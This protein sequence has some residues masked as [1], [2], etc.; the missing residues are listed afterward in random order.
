MIKIIAQVIVL[1]VCF[2][3]GIAARLFTRKD[4]AQEQMFE[5]MIVEIAKYETS[6]D[7]EPIVEKIDEVIEKDNK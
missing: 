6:I 4:K 1:G 3:I 2:V 5:D 7:I